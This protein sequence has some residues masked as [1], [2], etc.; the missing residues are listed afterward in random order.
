MVFSSSSVSSLRRLRPHM[1]S[2]YWERPELPAESVRDG[3]L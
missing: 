2:G 1:M 3:W